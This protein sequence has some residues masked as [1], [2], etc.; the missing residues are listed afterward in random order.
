MVV[1]L[2][3]GVWEGKSEGGGGVTCMLACFLVWLL[4]W[5][6]GCLVWFGLV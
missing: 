5:L 3:V 6:I 4:D 2:C 1:V